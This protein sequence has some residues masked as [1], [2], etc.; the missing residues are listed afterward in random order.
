MSKREKLKRPDGLQRPKTRIQQQQEV[1][2]YTYKNLDALNKQMKAYSEVLGQIVQKVEIVSQLAQQMITTMVILNEKGLITNDEIAEKQ[3]H[4]MLR[5]DEQLTG[6]EDKVEGG[7]EATEAGTAE[8]SESN[9][10][11]GSKTV[12]SDTDSNDGKGGPE[13]GEV[14]SEDTRTADGDGGLSGS[15]LSDSESEGGDR[16]VDDPEINRKSSGSPGVPDSTGSGNSTPH[17]S[18]D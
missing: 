10:Q 16:P 7:A 13:S 2:V 14:Q 5:V 6:L 9:S 12:S 4:L 1:N 11:E 3:R 18:L 8:T 17:I 15:E